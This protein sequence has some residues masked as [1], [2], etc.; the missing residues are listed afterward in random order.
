M[1]MPLSSMIVKIKNEKDDDDDRRRRDVLL[2]MI[3]NTA[4]TLILFRIYAFYPTKPPYNNTEFNSHLIH[5]DV[6]TRSDASPQPEGPIYT[7]QHTHSSLSTH[8]HTLTRTHSQSHSHTVTHTH[9]LKLTSWQLPHLSTFHC[10]EAGGVLSRSH[11]THA[12]PS[13]LLE[14]SLAQEAISLSFGGDKVG[15]V[16]D[17]PSV[18]LLLLIVVAQVAVESKV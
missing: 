10:L 14:S 6:K 15:H 16:F 8:T 2:I 17:P 1:W 12:L 18:L 9:S 7:P 13:L 3:F 11:H 5:S 4:S